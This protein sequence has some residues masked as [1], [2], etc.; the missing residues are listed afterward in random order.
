[1]RSSSLQDQVINFDG[2]QYRL[3]DLSESTR[4][5]LHGL[6]TAQTQKKLLVSQL[7]LVKTA[8]ATYTRQ[9]AAHLPDQK[10]PADAAEQIIQLDD[11]KYWLKDLNAD[12]EVQLSNL[13]FAEQEAASLEAQLEV[14]NTATASYAQSL[15]LALQNVPLYKKQ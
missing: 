13:R 6:S 7:A 1:M 8:K 2:S 9:L 10:A 3:G 12:A 4:E 15:E 14:V 5:L 11:D